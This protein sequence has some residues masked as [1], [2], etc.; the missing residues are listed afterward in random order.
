MYS[1]FKGNSSQGR[2]Y[3][4]S[5]FLNRC[6]S[7]AEGLGSILSHVETLVVICT[8]NSWYL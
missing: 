5:F 7:D 8:I 3:K 1:L 4:T 6:E 2:T